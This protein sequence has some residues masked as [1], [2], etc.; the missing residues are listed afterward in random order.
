VDSNG[1]RQIRTPVL[2][3]HGLR[4]GFRPRFN[5]FLIGD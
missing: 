3:H 1:R 4:D 5:E 2:F